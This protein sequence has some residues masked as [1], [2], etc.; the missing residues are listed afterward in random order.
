M[1]LIYLPL[2]ERPC[3]RLFPQ[4]IF[5][6]VGGVEL[7]SPPMDL[8]G[9]KKQASPVARL[10]EWTQHQVDGA[11]GL[12]VSL[13]QWLYGGLLPSRLHQLDPEELKGRLLRLEKLS[14]ANPGLRIFAFQLVMRCPTYDSDDEEPVY[15]ARFG[16]SI[17]QLGVLEDQQEHGSSEADPVRQRELI[18]RIPPEVLSD[19]KRRRAV[20]L[21]LTRAV[22]QGVAEGWLSVL[23]IPQ[24]DS[25]PWGYT[26]RDK[27]QIQSW[28]AEAKLQ[29]QVL[30]YP[31]A[32]EA[33]CTLCARAYSD[34]SGKSR[35]V[36]VVDSHA[37]GL[38]VVP[39]YE[40]QEL[41]LSIAT[42]AI[43]AGA[44]LGHDPATADA[45]LAVNLPIGATREAPA[46][47]EEALAGTT[48]RRIQ[49][50]FINTV[51]KLLEG[52][53]PVWLADLRF[54]NG[55]D[56]WLVEE[57]GRRGYLARLAGY[58][59]WNTCCNALGTVLAQTVTGS[60]SRATLTYRLCEDYGYMARIR[61]GLKTSD[62]PLQVAVLESVVETKLSQI[63]ATVLGD[64]FAEPETLF[65]V[66]FPWKRRFE[67]ALHSAILSP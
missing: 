8:L 10:H 3:N 29:D 53:V 66:S 1:K 37:E 56:P 64:L 26:A 30:T 42:H 32:D 55:A 59:G 43:A 28:L 15:W 6:G 11:H 41:G 63:S 44:F 52:P 46:G 27:R 60:Q 18:A 12:V 49:E 4:Q 25:S 2:D 31:G 5:D 17:H 20:N 22:I 58:S 13:E 51:G 57:L 23:T 40:G 7:V 61:P 39:D 19:Y 16:N 62:F 45:I 67:I 9:Q 47:A 50:A 48:E 33:G 24:D 35:R 38:R 54:T 36:C 21:E 34:L 14:R 65:K